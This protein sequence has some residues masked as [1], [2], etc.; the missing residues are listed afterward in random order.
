M[1]EEET[2]TTIVTKYNKKKAYNDK[3]RRIAYHSWC[4]WLNAKDKRYT[5]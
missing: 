2:S 5:K 3:Q 4:K 1:Q